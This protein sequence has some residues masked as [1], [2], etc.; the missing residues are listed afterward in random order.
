MWKILLADRSATFETDEPICGAILMGYDMEHLMDAP[1]HARMNRFWS[2]HEDH[3]PAAILFLPGPRLKDRG[4][5]W[6][7]TSIFPCTDAG[8]RLSELGAI[9]SSGL[10]FKL[11][12]YSAFLVR[13][14]QQ[15]VNS[16]LPRTLDGKTYFVTRSPVVATP[17]WAGLE[18]H[19]LQGLAIVLELFPTRGVTADGLLTDHALTWY[20][21]WSDRM[22]NSLLS[23]S[24]R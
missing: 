13:T 21:E 11:A 22:A 2:M 15:P 5:S 19:D 17:S 23:I 9:T 10:C 6:E 3:V 8:P 14:P 12:A 20:L 4:Y 7:P 1:E 18:L 16:V 24:D